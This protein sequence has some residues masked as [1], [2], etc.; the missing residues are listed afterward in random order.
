MT[1]QVRGDHC[2]VAGRT[3]QSSGSRQAANWL[4]DPFQAGLPS[5]AQGVWAPRDS[6][7]SFLLLV[8]RAA[9][10]ERSGCSEPKNISPHGPTSSI[11]LREKGRSC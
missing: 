11:G 8:L 1:A 9:A 7:F 10:W 5:L 2:S 4:G 6:L 3:G